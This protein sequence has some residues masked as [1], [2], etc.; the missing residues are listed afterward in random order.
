[1][2]PL[3]KK[4]NGIWLVCP[5]QAHTNLV[6]TAMQWCWNRNIKEGNYCVKTK[7]S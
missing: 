7:A 3:I 5:H 6:V 1:M 4:I 2:K